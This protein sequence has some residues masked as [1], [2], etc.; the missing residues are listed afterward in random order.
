MAKGI[1]VISAAVP[2]K[3]KLTVLIAASAKLR[4]SGTFYTAQQAQVARVY[5]SMPKRWRQL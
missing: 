1:T 2:N 4:F 3:V 5:K